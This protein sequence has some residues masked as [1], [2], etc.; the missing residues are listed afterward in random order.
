M[1]VNTVQNE[2]GRRTFPVGQLILLMLSHAAADFYGSFYDPILPHIREQMHLTLMKSFMLASVFRLTASF[3]QPVIGYLVS[4]GKRRAILLLGILLSMSMSLLG[5]AGA[6]AALLVVLFIGGL[7]VGTVHP[8]GAALAAA[9]ERERKSL[10][11]SIYMIGGAIGAMGGPLIVPSLIERNPASLAALALPGAAFVVLLAWRLS[12]SRKTHDDAHIRHH[13]SFVNLFKRVAGVYLHVAL[14]SVVII[15]FGVL[16]PLHGTSRGLSL[17]AAGWVLAAFLLTGTIS[18][19]IGGYL[20]DRCPRKPFIV[21]TEF[22]AGIVLFSAPFFSGAAFYSLLLGGASLAFAAM[23][24]QVVMAQERVPKGEGA[25]SGFV[26][27]F[28]HGTAALTLPLF[29]WLGDHWTETTGSEAIATN[30][31]LQLGATAMLV[32]AVVALFL[33]SHPGERKVE[34]QEGDS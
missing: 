16:L 28:A 9:A 23:P 11:I 18:S 12:P 24:L 1:D 33:K 2:G 30:R 14:R 26:M 4:E 5:L 20:T 3:L 21:L 31:Q 25:A 29:G 34:E 19:L 22:G 15:L 13:I 6:F 7:G 17:V 10:A 32:A 27:G 8:C